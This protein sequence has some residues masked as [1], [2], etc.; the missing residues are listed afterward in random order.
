[1]N[2]KEINEVWKTFNIDVDALPEYSTPIEQAQGFKKFT[3]LKN[4]DT[5]YSNGTEKLY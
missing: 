1:M 2:Q 3:L 5:V 4:I